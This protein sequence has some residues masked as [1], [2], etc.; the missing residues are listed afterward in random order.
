MGYKSPNE[1]WRAKSNL[2]P[3]SA[4]LDTKFIFILAILVSRL[5]KAIGVRSQVDYIKIHIERRL[6]ATV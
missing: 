3:N 4:L 6:E 5:I 2:L 1:I